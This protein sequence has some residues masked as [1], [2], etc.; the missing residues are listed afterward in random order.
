MYEE[1][2]TKKYVTTGKSHP[3]RFFCGLQAISCYVSLRTALRS[4]DSPTDE[5]IVAPRYE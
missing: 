3:R 4:L 1:R 2:D 5:S